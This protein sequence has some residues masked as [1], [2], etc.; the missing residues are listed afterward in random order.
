MQDR[1]TTVQ[2]RGQYDRVGIRQ[3]ARERKDEQT[4]KGRDAEPWHDERR[5]FF[6]ETYEE[7]ADA[8]NYITWNMKRNAGL[9]FHLLRLARF[10]SE[11]AYDITLYAEGVSGNNIKKAA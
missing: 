5:D 6:L 9:R 4:R 10:L 2:G 8:Y 3:L 11:L 1:R 7:L